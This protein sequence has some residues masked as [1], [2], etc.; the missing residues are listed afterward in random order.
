MFVLFVWGTTLGQAPRP[1]RR[2]HHNAT[3]EANKPKKPHKWTIK[4]PYSNYMQLLR[5]TNK[6]FAK[7][8]SYTHSDKFLASA[9]WWSHLNPLLPG[10]IGIA[11]D[12][13]TIGQHTHKVRS[14]RCSLM[15]GWES[16]LLL[17]LVSALA[18]IPAYYFPANFSNSYE[19]ICRK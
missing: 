8:S 5:V 7:N 10:M 15:S 9:I 3:H 17:R 14:I 4:Q 19:L 18:V 12:F 11:C 6:Q 16:L 13:S 2:K 1:K